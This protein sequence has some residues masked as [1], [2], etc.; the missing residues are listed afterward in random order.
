MIATQRAATV[1]ARI[2]THHFDQLQQLAAE[3]DTTISRLVAR[4]VTD[5]LDALNA[6]DAQESHDD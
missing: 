4:A 6:S 2:T 3:R 1:H 5:K